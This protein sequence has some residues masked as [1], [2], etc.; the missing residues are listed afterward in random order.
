MRHTAKRTRTVGIAVLML[1]A[2][3]LSGC[4]AAK[5]Q[6]AAQEV[7][8][9]DIYECTEENIALCLEGMLQSGSE[10]ERYFFKSMGS[11]E[12][13]DEFVYDGMTTARGKSYDCEYLTSRVSWVM[14]DYG[15]VTELELTV[16]YAEGRTPI[17]EMPVAADERSL[18][19]AMIAAWCAEPGREAAVLYCGRELTNAELLE[20]LNMASVNCVELPCEAN[21]MWYKQFTRENGKSIIAGRLELPIEGGELEAISGELKADIIKRSE[22]ILSRHTEPEKLYRA[23][24][25]EVIS[26]ASYDEDMSNATKEESLTTAM[27][28]GRSAYGALIDG[29]TV[30][31]GYAMAYKALCGR[32]GLECYVITGEQDGESHA[33][34]LVKLNG[35][36][37]YV[38]CS[39]ADTGGGSRYCLFDEET[40][41]RKG[42]T[43]DPG[44][45]LAKEW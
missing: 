36:N 1:C 23:A 18:Y 26:A 19:E 12:E 25:R 4:S 39:F 33:W 43:A 11:I 41:E 3:L 16:K 22:T 17:S 15:E 27:R 9:D 13:F 31:S 5:T 2:L 44:F 32:L 8:P 6:A 34:N 29:K 30:C 28:I 40:L 20:I 42:Y 21:K 24:Y 14:K 10:T 38:D 37:R 35:E 45:D 7:Y